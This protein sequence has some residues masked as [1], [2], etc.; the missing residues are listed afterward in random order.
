MVRDVPFRLIHAVQSFHSPMTISDIWLLRDLTDPC[1]GER[2]IE[3]IIR[4]LSRP[5]RSVLP[6]FCHIFDHRRLSLNPR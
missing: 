1:V 3:T 6:H 5:I 2:I 4:L